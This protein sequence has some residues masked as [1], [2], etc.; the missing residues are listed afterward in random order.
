[1][2]WIEES[3]HRHIIDH[4]LRLHAIV[5]ATQKFHCV[6]I[7]SQLPHLTRVAEARAAERSP[8][9]ETEKSGIVSFSKR[10]QTEKATAQISSATRGQSTPLAIMHEQ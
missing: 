4:A 5:Y 6:S 2:K 7:C 8:E 3:V 9:T 1:M 10:A